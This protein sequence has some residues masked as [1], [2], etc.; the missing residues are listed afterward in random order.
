[1]AHCK[2]EGRR[3]GERGEGREERGGRRGEGGEGRRGEGGEGR[4]G[5]GGEGRRGE[6]GEGRRGEERGGR[7][8]EERGGR[9]GEERGGRRGE[10]GEGM[11]KRKQFITF[12]IH[13][14][15][16]FTNEQVNGTIVTSSHTVCLLGNHHRASP[17]STL[18]ST[19]SIVPPLQRK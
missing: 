19:I 8:G 1:M 3:R 7:R 15:C 14:A 5:E 6:G 17:N 12:S 9:R 2:G 10:G 13:S 18:P 11:E 16:C 4:R